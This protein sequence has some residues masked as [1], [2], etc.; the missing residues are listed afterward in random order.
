MLN[1][2]FLGGLDID[3][4]LTGDWIVMDAMIFVLAIAELL[5]KLTQLTERLNLD[6]YI[7]RYKAPVATARL[8]TS[9]DPKVRA[10]R[11]LMPERSLGASLL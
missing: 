5:R 4:I 2:G 3:Y 6:M 1:Q 10:S 9:C 11:Y 7:Q 8:V